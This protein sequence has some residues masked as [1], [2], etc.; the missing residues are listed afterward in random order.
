MGSSAILSALSSSGLGTGPG[1]DVT[2]T[3][4]QLIAGLRAPE[5]VWQTQQQ[6][7]QGQV[8]SLQSLTSEV[9]TLSTAL[10]ALGDPAGNVT[11]RSV[12]SSQPGIVTATASNATP[13]G[14][15]TVV[16]NSLATSGSYYSASVAS[17]STALAT[18]TFTI[19]VGSGQAATITIDN[20]NNTLDKL[21]AAINTQ[22]LGA[23]ASVVNDSTGSRL[24]IVSDTSGTSG[25]LTVS[26]VAGG[27]SFTK[28]GTGL[29]A[30]LT[31]DG[32]PISSATNTVAGTV[33][34]LTLN[35][36]GAAP[37][38]PVQV[39]VTPDS[40][41]ISK[42]VTDFVDAYNTVIQDLSSQFT[43]NTTTKSSG[44]LASDFTAR[45]A[46]DQLLSA[47]SY[48]VPGGTNGFT[49]LASLGISLNNDGTLSVNSAQ[50]D[51]AVNANSADVQNFFQAA[52]GNGFATNLKTQLD[53]L[54]DPTQGAFAV[55]IHGMTSTEND[56]QQHVDDFEVYIANQQQLLTTQY[57]Q[58]NV[59]LQQLPLLQAQINAE[60]GFTSNSNSKG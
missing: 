12:T 36:V 60:L 7:L 50:L 27:L 24:S 19:Q 44:P 26:N 47:A 33:A 22:A 38:T 57:E 42:A 17:S 59:L 8:S 16:V 51:A 21:A 41:S 46:Q 18:G 3:V 15:H 48:S 32:V 28:G 37:N 54:T 25:D 58:V 40:S 1:I 43:Y 11:A 5:Q 30:S 9:S 14:S 31:V 39:N 4:N 23:T 52:N 10:N 53:S 49:T 55:D 20:T 29:D 2:S 45:L 34:G 13:S 35:L 56:L 6:E